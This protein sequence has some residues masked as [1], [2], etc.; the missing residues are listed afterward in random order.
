MPVLPPQAMQ[1]VFAAS[2]AT[3]PAHVGVAVA[4]GG[5]ALYRI[6]SVELAELDDDDPRLRAVA[7]DFRGRVAD[8]EFD[9]F[10]TSLR[11]QYKVEI[12]AAA[13]RGNNL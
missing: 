10:L 5:F 12:R 1:A 11:D 4:N 6:E 13:L 9:A 3:L 2:A 7:Q 8:K